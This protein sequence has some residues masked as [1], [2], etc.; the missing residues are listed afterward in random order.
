MAQIIEITPLAGEVFNV[1]VQLLD[2][3]IHDF[4]FDSVDNLQINV[5]SAEID[6]MLEEIKEQE[7]KQTG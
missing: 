5:D 7:I 1:R 3:R 6:F 4:R 2:G